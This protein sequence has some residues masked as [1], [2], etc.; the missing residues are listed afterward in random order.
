MSQTN[1]DNLSGR[2]RPS[3]LMSKAKKGVGA[4]LRRTGSRLG[5]IGMG[6]LAGERIFRLL[7]IPVGVQTSTPG[8]ECG[9]VVRLRA[10]PTQRKHMAF[11]LSM[12][13]IDPE[14]RV[15]AGLTTQTAGRLTF[16]GTG[17]A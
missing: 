12:R 2:P 13:G 16:H 11:A 5:R 7:E 9:G 6:S 14:D 1:R 3:G 17:D 10:I 15:P 4:V 8:I